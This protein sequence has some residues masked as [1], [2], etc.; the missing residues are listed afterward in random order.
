MKSYTNTKPKF[1]DSIMIIEEGVDVN[2]ADTVN[3][4]TKQ[5]LD[6][7]LVLKEETDLLGKEKTDKTEFATL[8]S[9][10]YKGVDLAV[11][12]ADEISNYSDVWAWLKARIT[13]AD[14]SGL[15]IGDYISFTANG[16]I[17]IAEIAG[18]D[19]YYGA[20][21]GAVGHHIDFIS[22][23]CYPFTEGQAPVWAS[24]NNNGTS[25]ESC[26]YMVSNIKSWLN[27]TLYG[28]LPATLKNVISDKMNYLET[29]YS[30]SGV[31]SDSTGKSWKNMGKLW[32]PTEYEVY[33]TCV[34]GTRIYSEGFNVWYPIFHDGLR[35][36]IK[37]NGNG[38]SRAHWWLASAYSGNPGYACYV[39]SYGNPGNNGV[40]Y[41]NYGVPVCFRISA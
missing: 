2:H 13:A 40:N 39:S 10:I 30:S 21:G 5:L 9:A 27:N 24:S 26:P 41:P 32:I 35:H 8:D 36:R 3:V 11:K 38:G 6:N 12:H 16:K 33:G 7:E 17:V 31:L 1:S 29:R 37:H 18:I 20:Y 28:Y 22:R 15:N 25:E 4:A 34:Y 23:D 14:F 19:V